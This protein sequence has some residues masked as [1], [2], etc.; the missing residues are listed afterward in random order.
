MG[1]ISTN[2]AYIQNIGLKFAGIVHAIVVENPKKSFP[3]L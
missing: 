2:Y 3:N 1:K